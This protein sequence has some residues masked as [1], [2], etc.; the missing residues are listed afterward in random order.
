MSLG[1]P[2]FHLWLDM[3]RLTVE[4]L[5]GLGAEFSAV[6][7]A[8]ISELALLVQ[9]V[10][11]LPS[12]SFTDG[13]PFADAATAVRGLMRSLLVGGGLSSGRTLQGPPSAGNRMASLTRSLRRQS[14][15]SN[16]GDLAGAI[17][18]LASP[19]AD[20]SRKSLF[21]RKLSMAGFCMRGGQPGIARPLLEELEQDIERFSIHE[22]EPSLALEAWTTLNRCYETLAAGPVTPAKQA[23]QQRGERVFERICRLDIAYALAS[24]GVKP[25]GKRPAPV[26]PIRSQRRETSSFRRTSG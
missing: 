22:W 6:R 4:A 1:Q 9:R 7:I 17:A 19:Q 12:L 15:S 20:S 3:Q 5:D 26:P 2:A 25:A 21:R 11:K 16:T 8:V 24:A 18:I 14:K 23:I 13:T 10:P